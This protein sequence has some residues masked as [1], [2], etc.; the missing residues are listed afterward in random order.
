[1]LGK[2]AVPDLLGHP[3]DETNATH[4]LSVGTGYYHQTE[5][6][7]AIYVGLLPLLLGAIAL[8]APGDHRRAAGAGLL[9]GALG[10]LWCFR[11]PLTSLGPF[12][13]GLGFSRPDRA[14][15]LWCF[16]AAIVAAVGAHRLAGPEGPGLRRATNRLALTVGVAGLGFAGLVAVLPGVLPPDVVE[17]IGRGTLAGAAIGSGVTALAA[18]AVVGLRTAGTIGGGGFLALALA[19]VAFD[20]G[21]TSMRMNVLQPE[22]SIFRAPVAGDVLDFLRERRDAEG[23]YRILRY[24]HA[25][26]QFVGIL[27]PSTAAPYGIEDTLGFDSINLAAYQE[28][29][30]AL[31]PA[32]VIKRG[33]FRGVQDASRL[34]SP[35]VDLLNVRWVLSSE[36]DP[37]PGLE[38]VREGPVALHEN[39]DALP[40]A[41]LVGEARP[42]PDRAERL[43][44][45]ADPGFR[46]DLWAYS[47]GSIPGLGPAGSS[48]SPGEARLTMHEDERVVVAVDAERPALLVLSDA[49][50]PGWHARVDGDERTIHRINHVFRGV[51]VQPGDREVEFRYEP[52]SFRRGRLVS[53]AALVGV[54]VGAIGLER[55][56]VRREEKRS[57]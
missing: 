27:P 35:L 51:V 44:A 10:L 42:I 21:R 43:A 4:L 30:S 13:P 19:L 17:R 29:M 8:V 56:R 40:R 6:S 32:I 20:L 28:F 39:G 11:T 26:T 36:G 25:P 14:A 37:L 22:A 49:W 2:L 1:V 5:R 3:V 7:T 9:I 45:L 41:F 23:P 38:A 52:A 15:Y 53:L 34:D 33:N 48:D 31:D 12:V 54:I 47:E 55:T 24:E 18:L 57:A 46:P 16:G 50:Y